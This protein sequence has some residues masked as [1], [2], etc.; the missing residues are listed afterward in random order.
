MAHVRIKRFRARDA[1]EDRAENEEGRH[2][3]GRKILEAMEWVNCS[4]HRGILGYPPKAKNAQRKKPDDHYRPEHPANARRALWLHKEKKDENENR[5][6]HH[7]GFQLAGYDRKTFERGKDGD[8]RGDHS[9]SID[10]RRT[11]QA[12]GHNQRSLLGPAASETFPAG[13]KRHQSHDAAFAMV[14]DPHGQADIFDRRYDDERPENE[15]E[16]AEHHRSI[17]GMSA[18]R[19]EHDFQRVERAC[20]DIAEN[21]AKSR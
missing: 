12:D 8:G 9:V 4:D 6:R 11:K 1:E 3:P 18:G 21:N 10:E 15:R 14:I 13:E 20:A 19:A 5:S 17:R 16:A 7:I 2:A